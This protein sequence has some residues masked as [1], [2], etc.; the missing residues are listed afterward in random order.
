[1]AWGGQ[2]TVALERLRKS[3]VTE[4]MTKYSEISTRKGELS[5][6]GAQRSDRN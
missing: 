3:L 1:M 4:S 2:V 5:K 6:L